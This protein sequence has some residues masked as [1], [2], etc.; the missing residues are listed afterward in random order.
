MLLYDI[1]AF[2][3]AFKGSL[4]LP[5]K[6]NMGFI[7]LKA[8][9]IFPDL[10]NSGTATVERT[11]GKNDVSRFLPVKF[12]G[13]FQPLFGTVT[14]NDPGSQSTT[15]YQYHITIVSRYLPADIQWN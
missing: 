1:Q 5:L 2:L 14:D 13:P 9:K 4:A 15:Q 10:F 7:N 3:A 8:Q 6:K 11:I 12:H